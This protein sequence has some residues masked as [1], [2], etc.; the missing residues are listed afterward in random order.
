[1][2]DS[3]GKKVFNIVRIINDFRWIP[4]WVYSFPVVAK[5]VAPLI[6]LF[7]LWVSI[8]ASLP[9]P[10]MAFFTLVAL[11]LIVLFAWAFR[12][13]P[14][15]EQ[16]DIV[17]LLSLLLT[18]HGDQSSLLTLEV[19]NKSESTSFTVQIRIISRSDCQPVDT[20]PYIG[21][22]KSTIPVRFSHE[23][24]KPP[25]MSAV[26]LEAGGLGKLLEIAEWEKNG[27]NGAIMRL[28]G[29][30]DNWIMWEH[31]PT[32]IE[33][34]PF[35]TLQLEFFGRGFADSVCKRYTVGPKHPYGPLVMT[36]VTA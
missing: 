13:A 4:H 3:K 7:L 31:K 8:F 33:K 6:A 21:Q 1:M 36:E 19:S 26:E 16:P 35:F 14:V 20:S 34:L 27:D 18:P 10:V 22:W 11:Y 15:P 2:E 32:P 9:W 17:K 30:N 23:Y 25:T 12:K 29:G 28:I 5:V 24:R